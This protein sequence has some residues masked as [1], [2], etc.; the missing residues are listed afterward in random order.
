MARPPFTFYRNT[1]GSNG[2]F[3]SFFIASPPFAGAHLKTQAIL[4]HRL[5]NGQS[6][7]RSTP[8]A[9]ERLARLSAAL[10]KSRLST[11]RGADCKLARFSTGSE[12]WFRAIQSRV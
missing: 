12:H 10:L 2:S 1:F 9:R 5:K 4:Q 7:G 6:A 11:C 8:L 3:L